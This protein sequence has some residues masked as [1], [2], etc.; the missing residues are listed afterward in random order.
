[1]TIVKSEV[2]TYQLYIN[3]DWVNP[4]SND[5]FDVVSPATGEVIAKAAHG[6]EQD[7][8]LAIDA[9]ATAFPEWSRK[10]SKERADIL[11]RL[12]QLMIENADELAKKISEEMGKPIMQARGEVMNAA[13]YVLWNAEEGKRIYGEI[14]PAATPDKRLQVIRHAVGPVAAITPWNFP[15]G[16]VARKV[17]PALAAG[18]TVV[19]KPAEQTP[20]S[21]I[22]FF[23]LAEEAG[24]PKGVINLV[25]GTPDK[26]GDVLLTDK[27]IRK[28]TFTGSTNVGKTLLKKAAEQVKRVSMELGGHAPFIVFEDADLEHATEQLARN[29]FLNCGQTCISANRIYVQ[30]SIKDQFLSMLKEKVEK[31]QVGY[32]LDVTTQVGP[33]VSAAGL[34]KVEDQVKEAVAKGAQVVTGGT[35]PDLKGY[36]EGF[37]YQPTILADVNES[38]R[39]AN[40]ET[41]GP[42]AP[43]YTFET[44][45]EVIAKAN[46]TDFG[47]AAYCFTTNLSRSIRVSESLE[48][49]MV[50]LNDIVLAQ[51][52][53]PFGG[54]KESGMGREGG[55]DG[56]ADFLEKK[57][58]STVY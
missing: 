17:A 1:M 28:V 43:I 23:R 7:T 8:K 5:Y 21:A 45:E 36:E 53:G 6:D 56:L 31:L 48:Y 16:M 46:D 19:L 29:K 2:T 4:I 30:A 39:I 32:G 13:D 26:I 9:A 58:I 41:F 47:L 40:E 11:T 55:P 27:R 42:I 15:L 18:C 10:T 57:F 20:G 52:E 49:G 54:V 12:H 34:K 22:L 38:M 35:K 50:G 44:E 3:G 14:I 24:I 37:F 33:L 25:T 51:V